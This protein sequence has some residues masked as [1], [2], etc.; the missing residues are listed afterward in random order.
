M[1]EIS[2][3]RKDLDKNLVGSRS[4]SIF[5]STIGI[6]R[7]RDE[8]KQ[9]LGRVGDLRIKFE[10][11]RAASGQSEESGKVEIILILLHSTLLNGVILAMQSP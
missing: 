7:D 10:T 9:I 4:G 11:R 3:V 6:F 2:R 1:G 5:I 8:Q